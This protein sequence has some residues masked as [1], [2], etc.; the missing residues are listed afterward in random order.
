[1]IDVSAPL[2]QYGSLGLFT[3]YLIFDRQVLLK[4]V[5]NAVEA[6]TEATNA[7]TMEIKRP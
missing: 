2:V 1:M 6:N 5:Q 7:L 3:A 4:G